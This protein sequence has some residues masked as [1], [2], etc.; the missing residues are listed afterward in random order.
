MIVNLNHLAHLEEIMGKG[1]SGMISL[2]LQ[3]R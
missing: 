3:W 1:L 2:P